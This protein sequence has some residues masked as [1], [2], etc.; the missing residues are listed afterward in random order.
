MLPNHKEATLVRKIFT[1]YLEGGCV[2]KLAIQLRLEKIKSKSWTTRTGSHRGGVFFA[3]GALYDLLRNRLYLGEIGHRGQWYAG[4]HEGIVPQEL[5]DRVQRQLSQNLETRSTRIRQQSSSLLTGL[6]EDANGNRFTPSFTVKSGRRYRY[7]VSQIAIKNPGARGQ[8]PSRIPAEEVE[9][10]VTDMLYSFLSADA[11]VFDELTLAG[12]S[13]DDFHRL[14]AGASTLAS[15]WKNGHVAELRKVLSAFVRRV[16]IRE[17]EI[18]VYISR[19]NLRHLLDPDNVTSCSRERWQGAAQANDLVCL[20]LEAKLKK[21]GGE[22]HLIV[23][24]HSSAAMSPKQSKPSLVKAVARAFGWYERILEGKALDQRSL[25]R[26][27][28]LTERYVGKV[29][30]FAFLAPDIVEAILDGRQPVDLN[31]EKLSKQIPLSWAEQRQR[32]GFPFHTVAINS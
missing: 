18:Q 14:I 9:T 27:S 20:T 15:R 28:S 25:A 32:F 8:G 11:R 12:E 13:A 17:N 24:P 3:R 29:L 7:Y 16:V 4:E 31:F 5:W 19:T 22:M 26:H 2:S 30:G 1:L 23:P 21:C 6:V 10:R